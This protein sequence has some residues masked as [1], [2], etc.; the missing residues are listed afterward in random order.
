MLHLLGET[1]ELGTDDVFTFS[2]EIA[3]AIGFLIIWILIFVLRNQYPQL[4]KNGWIELVIAAPCLILKGLFDGLDT[5]APD[6][7]FNLHNLF[8]SFEATFMLIGL[9]LLGVGLLRMALY[10]SKVWEVR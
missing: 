10:S 2:V 1:W 7:P 9:V 8:D 4:T 6:E 3:F 5:I